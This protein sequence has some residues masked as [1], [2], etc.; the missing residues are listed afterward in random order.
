MS[1]TIKITAVVLLVLMNFGLANAHSKIDSLEDVAYKLSGTK[2]ADALNELSETYRGKDE[3]SSFATAHEAFHIALALDYK[4][5]A[6]DALM[7]VGIYHAIVGDYNIAKAKFKRAYEIYQEIDDKIG[8]SK[9]NI[10]FG[11]LNKFKGNLQKA[12]RYYLKA[13]NLSKDAGCRKRTAVA[14][15]QIAG[16]YKDMSIYDKALEYYLESL[17]FKKKLKD[18]VSLANT[19]NS[20]G[21]I[22]FKK[23]TFEQALRYYDKARKIYEKFNEESYLSNIYNNISLIHFNNGDYDAAI[24]N[25]LI[26]LKIDKKNCDKPG[27]AISYL[28][29]GNFY[30]SKGENDKAKFYLDS[31]LAI[32]KEIHDKRGV[33]DAHKIMG[34]LGLN[35][36]RYDFAIGHLSKTIDYYREQKLYPD[37]KKTYKYL[38]EAYGKKGEHKKALGCLQLYSDLGDSLDGTKKSF[39][40]ETVTKSV[41]AKN[42]AD[43]AEKESKLQDLKLTYYRYIGVL[44]GLI[45]ILLV[46]IIVMIR[47]KNKRL[48]KTIE[49]LRGAYEFE[50]RAYEVLKDEIKDS[51][52]PLAFNIAEVHSEEEFAELNESYIGFSNKLEKFIDDFKERLNE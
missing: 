31:S 8:E 41:E 21:V 32:S 48:R 2:K 1:N 19:L 25:Q 47:R 9:A 45:I 4:K 11:R 43:E 40:I 17:E 28:N 27:I 37:L 10:A 6:A 14:L 23:G 3:E 16:V 26:S 29:L 44:I 49:E 24:K 35:M 39:L 52:S 22:H 15:H 51:L 20:I 7:N 38:S 34:M 18:S 30:S 46:T 50:K 5:G 36:K 12:L 42:A 13:L 33:A